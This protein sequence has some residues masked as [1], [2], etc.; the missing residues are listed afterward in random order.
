MGMYLLDNRKLWNLD[1]FFHIEDPDSLDEE[2]EGIVENLW[3]GIGA[4]ETLLRPFFPTY[5]QSNLLRPLY[6]HYFSLRELQRRYR[7]IEI[8]ASTVIVDI[9]ARRLGLQGVSPQGKVRKSGCRLSRRIRCRFTQGHCQ[10]PDHHCHDRLF[11]AAHGNQALARKPFPCS[12]WQGRSLSTSCSDAACSNC[13]QSHISTKAA[14]NHKSA[15]NV[16]DQCLT[17]Q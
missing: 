12:S 6:I 9:L 7:K 8:R 10:N 15:P 11:A 14:I 13:C 4:R 2:I 1:K 16:P 3:D 5:L 17:G